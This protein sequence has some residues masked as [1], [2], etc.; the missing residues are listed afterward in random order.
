MAMEDSGLQPLNLFMT[1]FPFIISTI[2]VGV[3]V[4][5]KTCERNFAAGTIVYS[6]VC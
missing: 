1:I 2:V 4:W 6:F 5:K 3:R